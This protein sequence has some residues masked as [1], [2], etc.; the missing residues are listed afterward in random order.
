MYIYIYIYIYICIY[1]YI[2]ICW[3]TGFLGRFL[4]KRRF[5][6]RAAALK[7]QSLAKLVAEVDTGAVMR[8]TVESPASEIASALDQMQYVLTRMK[9]IDPEG[10]ATMSMADMNNELQT[11]QSNQKTAANDASLKK[12]HLCPENII[13]VGVSAADTSMNAIDEAFKEEI[14]YSLY[15]AQFTEL[16]PLAA[17]CGTRCSPEVNKTIKDV[18]HE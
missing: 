2:Y 16:A 9:T 15:P 7:K 1:I 6:T 17:Q 4:F 12:C 11:I 5:I 13:P 10:S 3:A 8:L 14:V 18:C